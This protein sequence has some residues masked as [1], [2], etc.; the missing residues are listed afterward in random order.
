MY[1]FMSLFDSSSALGLAFSAA[2]NCIQAMRTAPH[3][4]SGHCD[5]RSRHHEIRTSVMESD[6]IASQMDCAEHVSSN[7]ARSIKTKD[8]LPRDPCLAAMPPSDGP[9]V[10]TRRADAPPRVSCR[11][12]H[13]CTYRYTNM[14]LI[15]FPVINNPENQTNTAC[16]SFSRSGAASSLK[17]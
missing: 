12:S 13:I 14:I 3:W 7:A 6:L 4:L 15:Y 8:H 9:R 16:N 11:P 10:S 2:F 17:P 1:P 5:F